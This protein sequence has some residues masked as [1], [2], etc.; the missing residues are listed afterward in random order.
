MADYKP[1]PADKFSFGLG[2]RFAPITMDASFVIT[3]WVDD[4][5]LKWLIGLAYSL[6]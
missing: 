6:P 1:T 5:G 2:L 4:S 3:K